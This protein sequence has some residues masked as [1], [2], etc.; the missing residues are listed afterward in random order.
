[1]WNDI[2]SFKSELIYALE[3]RVEPGYVVRTDN[4]IKNNN[5][6]KTGISLQRGTNA[7]EI[8]PTIYVE[9][10]YE[11][12]RGGFVSMETITEDVYSN[13]VSLPEIDDL[14]EYMTPEFINE[15]VQV[16]VISGNMNRSYL[17]DKP[18][19]P[20]EGYDDLVAVAIVDLEQTPFQSKTNYSGSFV[21]SD[22][23]IEHLG[24]RKSELFEKALSNSEHNNPAEFKT[25]REVLISTMFPEGI[26]EDDPMAELILPPEDEFGPQMY[27]LSN[28]K[29]VFGA[30][31]IMYSGIM[32]E[33]YNK[34]GGD[35]IIIP[36][37][38]H[39]VIIIK[40]TDP[41]ENSYISGMIGEI[42]ENIV[43]DSEV[44]SNNF[45]KYNGA[46]NTVITIKASDLGAENSIG[47][48]L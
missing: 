6:T 14:S 27:V 24:I 26:P 35:F 33:I 17:I 28:K 39:E 20:V 10:I 37:S 40:D 18:F 19:I 31:A 22:A 8:T 11:H 44:L 41:S 30:S 47:A 23:L 48:E 15:H 12:Y 32:Q 38:I 46:E 29:M 16:K 25:M 3:A 42:N 43:N 34:I 21:V 45:Y 36:S 1:M 13:L 9:D 4:V 7:V 2:D 5:I